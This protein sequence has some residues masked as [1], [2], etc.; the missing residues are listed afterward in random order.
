MTRDIYLVVYPVAKRTKLNAGRAHWAIWIPEPELD[1]G[2]KI[3]VV[4]SAF[5][6]YGLEFTRS[7]SLE[8]TQRLTR[9]ILLAS[10]DDMHVKDTPGS[11]PDVIPVDTLEVEAKKIDAPTASPEPFNPNIVGLSSNCF[12]LAWFLRLHTG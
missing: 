2:K 12:R 7:H 5:T 1:L 11:V 9:L 4:G 6:G 3:H 10:I 8:M